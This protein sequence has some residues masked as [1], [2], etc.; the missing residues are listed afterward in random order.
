M[1]W[2][3]FHPGAGTLSCMATS[4]TSLTMAG[5]AFG[6]SKEDLATQR[7]AAE[8]WS[9]V[10][11]IN[12]RASSRIIENSIPEIQDAMAAA[13]AAIA[14]YA[15]AVY[16]IN[17]RGVE[18]LDKLI[19]AGRIVA[20]F[21][22]ALDP[23]SVGVH[24]LQQ[25]NAAREVIEAE[26]ALLGLTWERQSADDALV[27]AFT[28]ALPPSWVGTSQVFAE[29]G[30]TSLDDL[31]PVAIASVMAEIASRIQF[32]GGSEAD[33]EQLLL[34]MTMYGR[35]PAVMD[36]LFESLGGAA[37]VEL[38]DGLGAA[39]RPGGDNAE[40]LDLAQRLREALALASSDWE[41][42]QST[43]FAHDMLYGNG[44]TTL[45]PYEVQNRSEA[46][47]W[48][49]S[50][51]QNALMGES[52]T[53]DLAV[54]IDGFERAEPHP[55]MAASGPLTDATAARLWALEH[56]DGPWA[57]DD[58]YLGSATDVDQFGQPI[59]S[60]DAAGRVFESLGQYPNSALAFL[61]E[62]AGDPPIGGERIDYWFGDRDW[63][64]VDNFQGPGALWYGVQ[65]ADGGPFF[66]GDSYVSATDQQIA[67]IASDIMFGLSTN[68]SFNAENL[69]ENGAEFLGMAVSLHLD[70]IA[71]ALA[72]GTGLTP[73]ES[74]AATY[75]LFGSD[76]ERWRPVF[77]PE[78][79][80]M[81]LGP[82]GEHVSGAAAIQ[83]AAAA[84]EQRYFD[85]AEAAIA[86]GADPAT[87][88]AAID[89]AMERANQLDGVI[90]SAGVM[91]RYEIAE[92]AD[93]RVDQNIDALGSVV[94]LIPIPGLSTGADFLAG[95]AVTAGTE[96]G[97]ML[98][99]DSLHQYDDVAAAALEGR[100]DAEAE[101]AVA[102]VARLYD[103]FGL[104]MTTPPDPD[105][106]GFDAWL[107]EMSATL[108]TETG[109]TY[110][111]RN[112]LDMYQDSTGVLD[113][114]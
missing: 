89:A 80:R 94:G 11:S 85:V 35:N 45:L 50:D 84:N 48:L 103:M 20:S 5:S 15:N 53:Y 112:Y 18:E 4:Q 7:L 68:D 64:G 92:R 62:T 59:A 100:R 38:I 105:G 52:L 109:G 21:P 79:L 8:S 34:L 3:Y 90:Q 33:R 55:V 41:P 16:S 96:V 104:E 60:N 71:G 86:S 32:D 49:F 99:S 42:P 10:G 57:V 97:G 98:W 1:N 69:S 76:D 6:R 37:T 108:S 102:N 107:D 19:R 111:F 110:S 58:G 39:V 25:A 46:I 73:T 93:E 47:G 2:D 65:Q 75:T 36:A 88:Q 44:A 91:E 74:G 56:P 28:R 31:T 87:V 61:G 14:T 63:S 13:K 9:G 81:L 27:G 113:V 43:D 67:G 24:D 51:T 29:L 22:P 114:P 95:L 78:V 101:V 70:S 83:E 72:D 26:A 77:T 30:I 82:I 66:T 17:A 23:I 54:A 40:I 106:G 12:W